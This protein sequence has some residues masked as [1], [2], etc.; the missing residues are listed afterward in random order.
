VPDE[1]FA[2]PEVPRTRTGKPL[3][4]P[5]KRMLMG[6]DADTVLDREALANPAALDPFL[7]LARR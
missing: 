3:E 6:A 4:V 5:V 1:V 7:E 2:V